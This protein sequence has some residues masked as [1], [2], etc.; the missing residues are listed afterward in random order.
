MASRGYQTDVNKKRALCL[1]C[2]SGQSKCHSG[3]SEQTKNKEQN[4]PTALHL[5]NKKASKLSPTRLNLF[6]LPSPG[7]R[8]F[9]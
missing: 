7:R 2:R 4:Q 5:N 9:C 6:I 1:L 8:H 3:L